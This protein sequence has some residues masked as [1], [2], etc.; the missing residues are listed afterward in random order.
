[1]GNELLQ[2]LHRRLTI[3]NVAIILLLFLLL[4]AGAYCFFKIDMDRMSDNIARRIA[5]D[6]QAGR[7]IPPLGKGFPPR[8][9]P[10]GK[11]PPP[12]F[13]PGG[14]PKP[15]FFFVKTSPAG[16]VT[17]QS[18]GH[19]LDTGELA[20]LTKK[21]L[22]TGTPQGKLDFA[23]DSYSYY[24]SSL[25]DGS[26]TLVVFHDTEHDAAM[27]RI[28]LTSLGVVGTVCAL[29]SFGASFF[30]ARRAMIP[31]RAAWQQQNNFL[32]DASHELRT[33]L[34]VIQTNL[35][36]VLDNP[37][38]T[39]ASQDKWLGNIREES[40]HMAK[41]V[42]SLLFL[43][44]ADSNQQPLDK[45]F[46]PLG[47][48]LGRAVAP[49]LPLAETKGIALTY[50]TAGPFPVYGDETRI[51]QVIGILLDNALRHTPS[52]GSVAVRVAR[53]GP[54][55]VL[56]VADSGEGIAA[57]YLD[58]IFDRFFQADRSRTD[59]GAGLGLAI[60][61]WIVASH[62]GT[63]TVTSTP[64]QGTTFAVKLPAAGPGA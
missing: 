53:Y 5:A 63:I 3:I 44:R 8:P 54:E 31:I 50:T 15:N 34:A 19:Q 48:V 51:R 40:V 64:G 57:E 59:S 27:L 24:K 22:E 61:K 10:D 47:A 46:F 30:M 43:A 41:L 7:D 60:A 4:T 11:E 18:A 12:D 16:D 26:G 33:P 52:G 36:V 17:F 38:E 32:S 6:V 2:K 37:D 58:K 1:M 14:P 42:D 13:L 9:L 35:D 25:E 49:F 55:I 20:E 56:S 21:A 62:D 23:Q 29:L 39:V 28:L 45:E